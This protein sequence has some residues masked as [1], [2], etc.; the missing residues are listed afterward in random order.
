MSVNNSTGTNAQLLDAVAAAINNANVGLNA[1]ISSP[2][3]GHLELTVTSNIPGT[4]GAFSISGA[5]AGGTSI[6]TRVALSTTTTAANASVT[7]NGSSVSAT[8]NSITMDN[9][10]VDVNLLTTGSTTITVGAVP[11][12]TTSGTSSASS[13]LYATANAFV[14]SFNSLLSFFQSNSLFDQEATQ[15][16]QAAQNNASALEAIGITPS[17]TGQ[18]LFVDQGTLAAS[19]STTSSVSGLNFANADLAG[20]DFSN[21]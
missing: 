1:S 4:A 17:S 11:T 5:D 6:A 10:A 7:V 20:Q 9:G 15:L 13:N 8:G 14:T 12:T 16:K 19:G 3:S 18:L 21:Q 2:S